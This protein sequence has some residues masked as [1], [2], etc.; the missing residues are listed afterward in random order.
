MIEAGLVEGERPRSDRVKLAKVPD[1]PMGTW[2]SLSTSV[3]LLSETKTVKYSPSLPK[4]ARYVS[5]DVSVGRIEHTRLP[6]IIC[7]SGVEH[8]RWGIERIVSR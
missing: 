4:T 5:E 7:H 2:T 6:V 8:D 1:A 3:E